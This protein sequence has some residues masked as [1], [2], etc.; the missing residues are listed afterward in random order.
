MIF[1]I[2][3]SVQFISRSSGI[4]DSV[5][6]L[7][8]KMLGVLITITVIAVAMEIVRD[9]YVYRT[10]VPVGCGS[11]KKNDGVL[12][13]RLLRSGADQ[14]DPDLDA[15]GKVSGKEFQLSAETAEKY[16]G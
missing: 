1:C 7:E 16:A 11:Y 4:L 9:I 12:R 14:F 2:I 15:E 10:K 13:A 3:I 8:V 6:F 5:I